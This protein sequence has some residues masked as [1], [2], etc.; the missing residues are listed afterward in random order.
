MH[1]L[2]LLACGPGAIGDPTGTTTASTTPTGTTGTTSTTTRTDPPPVPEFGWKPK[3]VVVGTAAD[4][5]ATPRDL[6]F[7]PDR[8]ELWVVNEACDC[9]V[10]WWLDGQGVAQRVEH[11]KD[12]YAVHF[13]AEVSAVAFG[14]TDPRWEPY[15]ESFATC[16]ESRNTYDGAYP[17]N[18]FMGPALWSGDYEL[19]AAP[20]YQFGLGSHLDMLHEAPLCMGIANDPDTDGGRAYWTYNG[21]DAQLTWF[22]FQDDHGPGKDDHDDGR[23]HR[24]PEVELSYV[25]GVPGHMEVDADT[26][27]LY[28]AEPGTGEVV[29]VDTRSGTFTAIPGRDPRRL[30]ILEE[31]GEVTGVVFGVLVAQGLLT[32]PSGLALHD[33]RLFVGDHAT[34][35]IVAFDLDGVELGRL[36]TG[37]EALMGITF[38]ADGHL[39]YVDGQRN[40]LWRVD[41]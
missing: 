34:G 40:E 39:W 4:G 24:Y 23:V 41:P 10:T 20:E 22:D 31:Y 3:L 9:T 32:E 36:A 12:Y 33:G 6:A 28:I 16:Q 21:F 11:H 13:M 17:P 15:E 2:I 18:D 19:Y 29:W 30:E 7:H 1:L 26:G 37:A 14:P 38:D 27:R 5:L 8:N 25:E 35:E